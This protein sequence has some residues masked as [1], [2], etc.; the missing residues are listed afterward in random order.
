MTTS[1]L[2]CEPDGL[3]VCR[4]SL[5][6]VERPPA[7]PQ[8]APRERVFVVGLELR[9]APRRGA[10]E[11]EGEKEGGSHRFCVGAQNQ[12]NAKHLPFGELQGFGGTWMAVVSPKA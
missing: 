9:L 10:R 7:R 11:E 4:D 12:V 6:V 5:E 3:F 2:T 8:E 1:G